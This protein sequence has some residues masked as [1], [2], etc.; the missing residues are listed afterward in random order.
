MEIWKSLALLLVI[1]LVLLGNANKLGN[2]EASQYVTNDRFAVVNGQVT[3]T[4]LSS[5]EFEN[6]NFKATDIDINFPNG[7]NKDNSI[8]IALGAKPSSGEGGY[9]YGNVGELTSSMEFYFGCYPRYVALGTPVDSNKI[10]LRFFNFTTSAVPL[11]YKL[12]LMK[13]S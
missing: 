3:L 5:E 6:K 8:V 7:F 2:K 10:R 11:N 1:L 13:I 12:V 9:A 4:A